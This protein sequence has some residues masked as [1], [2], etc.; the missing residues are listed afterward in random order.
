MNVLNLWV[1]KLISPIDKLLDR[2]TSY[3][4][5]LYFLFVLL[6]WSIVGSLQH[7]VGYNLYDIILSAVV[8]FAACLG[9]NYLISKKLKIAKNNESDYISALILI[10]ILNPTH[11]ASGLAILAL[12]GIVA[13]ASKYIL[14]INKWHI[15]NPAAFGAAFSGL[16]FHEY[17]SWWVGTSFMVPIVF[18]GGMLVL[19]KMKRFIMAITF[20]LVALAAIC[21]ESYLNHNSTD[22]GHLIWLSLISTSLLFFAYIM[23][24]EP[25]T[26][27][28]HMSNYLPYAV[29]VGF[30][31][32]YTKLGISPEQALLIG[33]VFAYIIEPNRRFELSFVRKVTEASGI[34]SFI[35]SGKE[36]FKYT[37]GQYMEWTLQDNRPDLRGNRRYL[38]ISSSPTEPDLMFTLRIP[39]KKSKFKQN[40]EGF[41]KGD[42]ILASQL[43]GEFILPKSEKQKL[44]FLAGGVGITPF[45]S[46]IKY[47]ADFG[48]QRDIHLLYSANKEDEFAFKGVFG[49]AKK[50]G[51]E[52]SYSAEQIT[53]EKITQTVP[54]YKERVF[55]ISG[56]YGFVHAM[57]NNLIGL[58]LPLRQI[59]TDYFPG[60]EG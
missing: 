15:F 50:F 25:Q 22:F 23:L 39:E 29:L 26:T 6:I 40:L 16:A 48:H 47:A 60:Y 42:K 30:L 8:L 17:A 56:P 41:K 38:T 31:Y 36:K 55:Y 4:L 57:E 35:F 37:A 52:T 24:T 3:R 11:S 58:G 21:A 1:R 13:M 43:A 10:L 28:R 51:V 27:P 34:D 14:V 32:G 7:K 59:K 5:V 53:A 9:S 18:I 44:A 46:M 54:D 2:L 45:R 33:N 49:E 12:A 20:E 19:R